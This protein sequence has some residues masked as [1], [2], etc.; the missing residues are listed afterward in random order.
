MKEKKVRYA[1]VSDIDNIGLALV[2]LH[3][4]E[5]LHLKGSDVTLL[6]DIPYMH[7]FSVIPIPTRTDILKKGEIIGHATRD[8]NVGEHVHTH[9]MHGNV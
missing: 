9:N 5:V 6:E 2:N 1:Q 8:I 3:K 4:G 7:K